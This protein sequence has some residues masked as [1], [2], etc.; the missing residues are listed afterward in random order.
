[1]TIFA[2]PQYDENA[3]KNPTDYLNS[4]KKYYPYF[5]R[6]RHKNIYMIVEN[7]ISNRPAFIAESPQIRFILFNCKGQFYK[8]EIYSLMDYTI[9]EAATEVFKENYNNIG[10][11]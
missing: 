1:M 5:I 3:I 6:Y 9:M 7:H 4:D 10:Y 11:E 2:N 8:S